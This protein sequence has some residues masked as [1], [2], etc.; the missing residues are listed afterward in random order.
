MTK[1][2]RSGPRF[3]RRRLLKWGALAGLPLAAGGGYYWYSNRLAVEHS[4]R[5]K[6]GLAHRL[7]IGV[8]SD[9]HAPSFDFE[10][11]D[12]RRHVNEAKCDLVLIT[13]DSIDRAGNEPLVSE[14][15]D[16]LEAGAGKF[17][18]LGNWEYWGKVDT[19]EL[20]RRYAGVGVSLLVNEWLTLPWHGTEVVLAGLDDLLGGEPDY[21]ILSNSP[22]EHPLIVLSHCPATADEIARAHWGPTVVFSGHTHGGQVAP[23]GWAVWLPKGSGAYVRDWYET[24]FAKHCDLYV[25]PGLGTSVVPFR[26]GVRPTFAIVDLT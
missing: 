9:L 20:R 10:I 25:S 5:S 15:F 21:G 14:V 8:I 6:L 2:E 7:R 26:L 13:G 3:N 23:F 22:P 19:R 12:L 24:G 18:I 4:S 16:G 17:A 1:P 11:D